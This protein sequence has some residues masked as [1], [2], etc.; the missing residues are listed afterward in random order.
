MRRFSALA[1]LILAATLACKDN[2]AEPDEPDAEV[3]TDPSAFTPTYVE[4]P[5]GGTVR[6]IIVPAPNGEGHDVTFKPGIPGAPAD[7]P[8]T[9]T[10]AKF[11]RKFETKGTFV[12]DCKVH[13]GMF[14][15]VV[16]K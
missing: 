5:V 2:P 6:W 12:Y 4:I 7:I 16:V 14:G 11:D 1:I 3:S 13:P 9:D 8:V 10:T 15:E